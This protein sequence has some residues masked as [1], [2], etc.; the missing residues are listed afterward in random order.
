[1]QLKASVSRSV[2]SE[3]S[4]AYPI[5]LTPILPEE[6][7]RD[8]LREV[9]EREGWEAVEGEPDKVRKSG[10]G[11]E[12][13]I[14]DLDELELVVSVSEE[15]EVAAEV[16]VEGSA[17]SPE[18]ASRRAQSELSQRQQAM[19]DAIEEAAQRELNARVRG[20]LAETEE[21]RTRELN[22]ILQQVYAESL[23]RKA[24]QMGDILEVSESTNEDGNYELVI[25]VGQ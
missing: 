2:R 23:K 24:G 5:D 18:G 21:V 9:L 1:V 13:M 4:V 19:G 16:E 20:R 7:M 10:P 8:L 25:R 17:E 6:E 15:R 14:L 12:E 22:E 11:D 3:D